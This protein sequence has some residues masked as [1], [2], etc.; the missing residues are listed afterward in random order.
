MYVGADGSQYTGSWVDNRRE[1]I[2]TMLAPDGSIFH[3]E[4]HENMKHGHGRLQF[5][6]GNIFEGDWQGNVIVAK[7]GMGMSGRFTFLCGKGSRGGPEE[8]TLKV[9]PY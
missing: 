5:P 2:G 6:D 1:G 7:E 3:G 4:Y 9:F 8:I